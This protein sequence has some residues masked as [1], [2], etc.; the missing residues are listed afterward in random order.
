MDIGVEEVIRQSISIVF[1][2]LELDSIVLVL[3]VLFFLIRVNNI[4]AETFFLFDYFIYSFIHP[5]HSPHS[6]LSPLT[7]LLPCPPSPFPLRKE[8]HHPTQ[9]QPMLAVKSLQDQVRPLP[10]RPDKAVQ[11]GEQDPQAGSR[12]RV[13][14]C[15]SCWGIKLHI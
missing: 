11:L 2:Q 5:D 14:P 10:L 9:Y 3:L 12:V 15:S 4:S 13:S 8:E 7:Q 6:L 1:P